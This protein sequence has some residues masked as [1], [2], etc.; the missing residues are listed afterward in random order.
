MSTNVHE[1]SFLHLAHHHAQRISLQDPVIKYFH[2]HISSIKRK[3]DA[4]CQGPIHSSTLRTQD[5]PR[6]ERSCLF[7]VKETTAILCPML[8]NQKQNRSI[9]ETHGSC[10]VKK[11]TT[12]KPSSLSITQYYSCELLLLDIMAKKEGFYN[13]FM[14]RDGYCRQT[15][16]SSNQQSSVENQRT[17]TLTKPLDY[18]FSKS[19]Q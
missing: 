1:C 8:S 11:G 16:T 9:R 13:I 6:Q 12:D 14:N 10:H 7:A 15:S 4:P 2:Y 5:T 3:Q 17:L 19:S 18:K